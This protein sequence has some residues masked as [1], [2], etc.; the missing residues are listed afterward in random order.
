MVPAR[1]RPQGA[2]PF[3]EAIRAGT[4]AGVAM[5]PFAAVFR[6]RGL[7]INEYGRKTLELVVGAVPSPLHEVLTFVEH[8]L[9]SWILALPAVPVLRRL[10]GR[11]TRLLGGALYGGGLYVG[12]NS[13]ALPF[14]FG[15]PTPWTLGWPTVA[16]SLVVHLVYGV[17][18][19][20]AVRP[21]PAVGR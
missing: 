12:L 1:N 7:R 6:A 17:V 5:I 14:A 15:D 19:G 21:T 8:L 20:L 10:P 11:G 16:P 4:M 9:V 2:L 18:L 3:V 13:L